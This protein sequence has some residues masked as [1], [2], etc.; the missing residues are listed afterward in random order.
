MCISYRCG[1]FASFSFAEESELLANGTA[2]RLQ[3]KTAALIAM[4][5]LH[6]SFFWQT[7]TFMYA[8]QVSIF[9]K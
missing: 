4:Q 6:I 5:A 8:L 7:P 2:Q 1:L 3:S 9:C